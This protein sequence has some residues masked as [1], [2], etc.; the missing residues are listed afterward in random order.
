MLSCYFLA[1]MDSGEKSVYFLIF[2]PLS[3][4][5]FSS[6][7]AAFKIFSLCLFF[8]SLNMICLRLSV[9]VCVCVCVAFVVL[10]GILGSGFKD[11]FWIEINITTVN[12]INMYSSVVFSVFTILCNC[13]LSLVGFENFYYFFSS[14][15]FYI[16]DY[17][18]IK[19]SR[20][21]F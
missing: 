8:S 14:F 21:F 18:Y 11:F 16:S 13:N 20:I 3:V 6:P 15:F 17:V 4:M 5:S 9:L 2:V 12:H 1:C 10:L 19:Y 7:L